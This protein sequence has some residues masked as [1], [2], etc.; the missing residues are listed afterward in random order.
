MTVPIQAIQ[1]D[2]GSEFMAG[3]ETTCH[4]KSI[5][6]SVLPPRSPKLNGRVERLNGTVRRELWEC[7]SGDLDLP[8]VQQALLRPRTIP[9]DHTRRS[10]TRP[11][12][13][14]LI[15]ISEPTRP[16]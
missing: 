1:V 2:D 4:A 13:L 9:S 7:Y 3:F 5:A 12:P 14:S 10:G 11:P 16:Y 15:H 6:L 8:T